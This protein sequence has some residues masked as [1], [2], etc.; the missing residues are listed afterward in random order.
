MNETT[1]EELRVIA[2]NDALH[3]GA[4]A[5]E[6]SICRVWDWQIRPCTS[7]EYLVALRYQ[8]H[9]KLGT[10][11]AP[12]GHLLVSSQI[13]WHSHELGLVRTHNTLYHLMGPALGSGHDQR[14]NDEP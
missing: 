2:H 14:P 7:F 9:P 5:P 8:D 12:F 6:P 13:V 4:V 10:N 1:A 11:K 3:A